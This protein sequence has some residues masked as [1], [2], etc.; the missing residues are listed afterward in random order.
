MSADNSKRGN[1]KAAAHQVLPRGNRDDMT[2]AADVHALPGTRRLTVCHKCQILFPESEQRC[3]GCESAIPLKAQARKP[4]ASGGAASASPKSGEVG[5]RSRPGLRERFA[6]AEI[7][8]RVRILV[9]AVLAVGLLGGAYL[10]L[11]NDPDAEVA[12]A[13]LDRSRPA[14]VA[15]LSEGGNA[16]NMTELVRTGKAADRAGSIIAEESARA[17]KLEDRRYGTVVGEDLAAQRVALAPYVAMGTVNPRRVSSSKLRSL[18]ADVTSAEV[19]SRKRLTTAQAAVDQVGALAADG[20]RPTIT[21]Q[22]L[23]SSSS[24]VISVLGAAEVKISVWEKRVE[25]WRKRQAARKQELASYVAETK[26]AMNDYVA[27]RSELDRLDGAE[28]DAMTMPAAEAAL[29]DHRDRRLAVLQR[30]MAVN[31][32]ASIAGIH[33]QLEESVREGVDGL[34]NAIGAM[35]NQGDLTVGIDYYSGENVLFGTYFRDEPEWQSYVSTSSSISE[36][37][38]R[39]MPEWEQQ[40]N[41]D[42]RELEAAKPPK[43]PSI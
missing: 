12:R 35:G 16:I 39:L 34:D 13:A 7:T 42:R 22:Q 17:R 36:R 19:T 18:R 24:R 41:A 25:S 38:D 26:S 5:N 15:V 28:L 33:H 2:K 29:Q 9:G 32:T 27:M 30:L 11:L 3:P 10:L 6:G 40:A 20:R 4:A 23:H 43:R 31:P 8:N 1:G 21:R 37:M 14:S